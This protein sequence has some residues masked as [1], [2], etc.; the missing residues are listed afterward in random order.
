MSTIDDFLFW[1]R[2]AS[3]GCGWTELEI[4]CDFT[5]WKF[6]HKNIRLSKSHQHTRWQFALAMAIWRCSTKRKLSRRCV[7]LM[8]DGVVC[9][10]L[11]DVAK[12]IDCSWTQ[13]RSHTTSVFFILH[14]ESP[15]TGK[16]YIIATII[17]SLCSFESK[18][19]KRLVRWKMHEFFFS[20]KSNRAMHCIHEYLSS[21]IRNVFTAVELK[22]VM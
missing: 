19:G 10:W 13:V 21:R 12:R 2:I 1:Q 5:W 11:W 7:A 22:V 18:R 20:W 16:H 6:Y 15:P 8:F 9:G 14:G 17:Y 4:S 3:N